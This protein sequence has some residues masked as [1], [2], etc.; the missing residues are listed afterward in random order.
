[1]S[2][3]ACGT[4]RPVLELRRISAHMGATAALL[5]AYKLLVASGQREAAALIIGKL[6]TIQQRVVEDVMGRTPG[7]AA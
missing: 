6:N 3:L 2:A 1:M 5:D 4:E 7:Q